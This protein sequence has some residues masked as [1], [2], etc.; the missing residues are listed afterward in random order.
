MKTVE[1]TTPDDI[2]A[3]CHAKTGQ[4]VPFSHGNDS[5]LLGKARM[6]RALISPANLEYK[7]EQTC[8]DVWMCGTPPKHIQGLVRSYLQTTKSAAYLI[9]FDRLENLVYKYD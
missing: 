2:S 7:L 4:G 8:S 9:F 5:L 3:D 6:I 1:C